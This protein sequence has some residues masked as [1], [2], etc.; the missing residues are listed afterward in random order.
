M[1]KS[2]NVKILKKD[3][4]TYDTRR[5]SVT[6]PK[7]YRFISGQATDIAINLNDYTEKK[8]P[9]SFTSINESPNLEFIIKIYKERNSVTK[10]L[11]ELKEGDELIIREPFGS[12]RYFDRGVFI[13]GGTGIT[14]FISIFRQLKKENKLKGNTLIFSNKTEKDI[15]LKDELDKMSKEGLK[16]IYL[17]TEENNPKY[18]NEYINENF[19]KNK[20]KDFSQHFYVCGPVRFVGEIQH[21]LQILGAK[22]DRIIVET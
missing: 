15:I 6:K 5:F 18:Y 12:I 4:I 10:K 11:S 7:N 16:C 2:F 21:I 14:P 3:K 8:R 9:F 22:P 17:I 20:I 13:A 1:E 19:L